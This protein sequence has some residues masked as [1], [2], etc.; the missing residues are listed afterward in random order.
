[1]SRIYQAFANDTAFVAF[2]TAG[3]PS[4]AKTEEY[5]IALAEAGAD[6]I[7]IGIPF[8]DPV[9]EG[10]T[11]QRANRRA[12]SQGITTDDIFAMIKNVRKKVSIPL[13]FLTYINPIFTYGSKR[14]CQKCQENGIDGLIIPDLPF[15]EKAEIF[16]FTQAYGIDIISLIAPTSA[17]RIA[18][19]AQEAQ[20]FVYLV[21]S[22]GVT[23]VRQEITSDLP[24]IIQTIKQITN[25]PIAVGFGI[26]TPQ[27]AEKISAYADGVI[28]GSAIVK[29]IEDYKGNATLQLRE[30]VNSMKA[31]IRTKNSK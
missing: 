10:E 19:I 14:F 31:A 29:I 2:L 13:V 4:L 25:I 20:G 24:T 11:I 17:Q 3:D 12:L 16:S 22:L 21:S 28:V 15:E 7:E 18:M 23:G 1:M 30:Y 8:S 9:A 27:Q 5:I 26:A 6:L